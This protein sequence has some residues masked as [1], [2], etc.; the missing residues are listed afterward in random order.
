MNE[1]ETCR[2]LVR[3]KLESAGGE[4][5]ES[6]S[7]ANNFTAQTCGIVWLRGTGTEE[8]LKSQG[9]VHRCHL[10]TTVG[11]INQWA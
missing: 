3:P 10:L 1:A 11:H 7:P 2:T 8:T 4:P 6:G 5:M 9:F